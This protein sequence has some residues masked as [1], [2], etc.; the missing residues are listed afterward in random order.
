ML[1]SLSAKQSLEEESFEQ[2]GIQGTNKE[3]RKAE[4]SKDSKEEKILETKRMRRDQEREGLLNQKE[5]IEGIDSREER[6]EREDKEEIDG[7]E[8]IE[9]K[10][11]KEAI[12]VTVEKEEIDKL[13]TNQTDS[14]TKAEATIDPLI[15]KTL[16]DLNASKIKTEGQHAKEKMYHNTDQLNMNN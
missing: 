2:I 8:A 5:A 14:H 7:I 13:V 4:D 3:E 10:E 15:L 16:I 6:E 11:A 12:E 1:L 9:A